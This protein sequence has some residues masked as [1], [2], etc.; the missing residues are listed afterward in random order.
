MSCGLPRSVPGLHY[1]IPIQWSKNS[2]SSLAQCY[3]LMEDMQKHCT[4]AL[5]NQKESMLFSVCFS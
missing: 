4:N 1:L 5:T 3:D 2:S